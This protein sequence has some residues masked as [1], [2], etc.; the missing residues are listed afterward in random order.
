MRIGGFCAHHG[1]DLH[2]A[3][4]RAQ[5]LDGIVVAVAPGALHVEGVVLLPGGVLGRDVELG[6]VEVVGLDVWPL[7][8][9]KA[10]VAEDLG[11]LVEH[12]AD[13][14]DAPVLQ[15]AEPHGQRDVGL[16]GGEPRRE[17]AALQLGLA[18]LQRLADAGLEA[19]DGL[20]E[21]LALI[22]RQRAE[23]RHQLGD[24]PLLAERGNAHALD[25]G[26]VARRAD[27]GDQRALEGGDVGVLCHRLSSRALCPGSSSP[28]TPSLRGDVPQRPQ[29]S[30]DPWIPGTSPGMTPTPL[31][32]G[33]PPDR[34]A[35]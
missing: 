19:V 18:R 13:R 31:S 9:G 11:D 3:R 7:G 32:A 33:R 14:M 21:G 35:P 23:L 30:V 4:V 17:R 22:G 12:L 25:G 28:R 16:L 15:R 1:A 5:H 24:A 27:L 26:Q 10:H 8:D 2:G 29:E 20:P 6:E 34:R